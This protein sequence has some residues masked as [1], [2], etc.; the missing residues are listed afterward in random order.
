[1]KELNQ[2]LKDLREKYHLSQ[3]ELAEQ[4]NVTRQAISNYERGKTAP[5]IFTL[6]KIAEIYDISIDQLLST[7]DRK[8][9]YLQYGSILYLIMW[10]L[11]IILC[12]YSQ[13]LKTIKLPAVIILM[14][15]TIYFAF[16]YAIR[17][18]DYTML[19]GY[20]SSY[21]YH[22]PTLRQ[23]ISLMLFV[24]VLMSTMFVF[25]MLLIEIMNVYEFVSSFIFIVYIGQF[26]IS[27]VLISYKYKDKLIIKKNTLQMSKDKKA[28]TLF[29]IAFLCAVIT[30][31][32][33]FNYYGI[34]NNTPEAIKMIMVFLPNVAIFSSIPV[35]EGTRKK[36]KVH[37]WCYYALGI[38]LCLD[39]IL[40][41]VCKYWI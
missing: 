21:Q 34:K 17:N 20:N 24:E 11:F 30:F 39:V 8:K 4:L 1:M 38:S 3:E 19:A 14:S 31:V 23:M 15:S 28:T 36:G 9:P 22:Y 5:D 33:C 40:Y 27:I 12:F 7:E 18:D 35:I 26:I 10:I 41:F 37:Y 2:Q 6:Q 16:G 13:D 32:G 29:G 25:I